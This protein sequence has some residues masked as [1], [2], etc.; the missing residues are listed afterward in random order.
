MIKGLKDVSKNQMMSTTTCTLVAEQ[1]I[2]I[3][4]KS[5]GKSE[6][7][8][9]E[10]KFFSDSLPIFNEYDEELMDSLMICEDTCDLLFLESDLVINNEQTIAELTFLQPE[11]SN[12]LILFSQDFEEEPFDYSHQEPLL[13][14]RKPL[15]DSRP[16]VFYQSKNIHTHH[17]YQGGVSKEVLVVHEKKNS[18]KII[19][20]ERF[21]F[22]SEVISEQTNL[23]FVG[24]VS[25][26][27]QRSKSGSIKRL[28][29]PLVPPFNPS[30]LIQTTPCGLRG[31][32][33]L[34]GSVDI[35]HIQCHG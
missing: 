24:L 16:K 22:L 21:S 8:L 18:T 33:F 27:K 34:S 12:S 19:N 20:F 17:E 1:P 29:T 15:E 9:E 3:S 4:E 31:M 25:H 11:H 2:F 10:R 28:S 35:V 32:S 5:K 13:G 23:S 6:N 26:I 14:T 30:V 7:N